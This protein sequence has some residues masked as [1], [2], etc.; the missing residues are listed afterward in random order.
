[1]TRIVAPLFLLAAL[2]FAPAA[3]GGDDDGA[4]DASI[5]DA[6][7]PRGT[8]SMSW[9]VVS[10]GADAMCS[11]VGA[12]YVFLE[13][14]R[15]GEAA[16][17]ADTLDCAVGAATTREVNAGTYE[18]RLDLLDAQTDSLLPEPVRRTGIDVNED[19]DTPIGEVV[20]ELE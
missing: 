4:P 10:A 6:Q 18:V 15:E 12:V 5:P 17:E 1:M 7:P 3:C 13:L 9:R 11:D 19:G 14:V 8:L 2:A 20:F 16:G